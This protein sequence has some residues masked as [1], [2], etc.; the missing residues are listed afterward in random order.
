MPS[1]QINYIEVGERLALL[2]A[3]LG[4]TQVEISRRTG[5]PK[6]SWNRFE[7]GERQILPEHA[8]RLYEVYGVDANFV[9]FGREDGVP[10]SIR[11]NF[12]TLRAKN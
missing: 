3:A 8:L 9:Y 12:P 7:K 5:I 4:V 10:G 11:D 1:R 6:S 2:R